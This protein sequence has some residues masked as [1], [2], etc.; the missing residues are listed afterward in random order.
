M[1]QNGGKRRSPKRLISHPAVGVRLLGMDGLHL[2]LGGLEHA[3]GGL[4]AFLE[5]L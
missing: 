3:L 1:S 5:L 4:K 2:H